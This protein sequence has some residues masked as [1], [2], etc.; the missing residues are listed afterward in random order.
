M[1]R[2]DSSATADRF[3]AIVGMPENRIET[4]NF[5]KEVVRDLSSQAAEFELGMFPTNRIFDWNDW[6]TGFVGHW[7][8]APEKT[9]FWFRFLNEVF[10]KR[11]VH[12]VVSV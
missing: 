4:R 11:C 6:Q 9:Q 7:G 3:D 2:T 8:Y 1:V 12:P 10:R 5:G